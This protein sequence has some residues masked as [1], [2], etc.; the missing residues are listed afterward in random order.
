MKGLVFLSL[1]CFALTAKGQYYFNDII[2]IK[3]GNDQYKTLRTQKISMIK[4]LSFEP[5]NTPTE[6]FSVTQ[7]ISRDGKK[8]VITTTSNNQVS[9]TTNTY[10]LGVLKRTQTNNK[11][12]SNKTDYSYDAQGRISKVSLSTIDTFM[13]SIIA[14]SH[15]WTYDEYG[16]P[17][18]MLKIKNQSDTVS[19]FFKKDEQENI[20]EEIWKKNGRILESYYYYYN[21]NRQLTDIVRYNNRLKKLLPDYIYEYNEVNQLAQMTQF[22]LGSSNYFIWKYSYNDKG[23]KIQETCSD[24]SKRV[25]GRIEY[26]YTGL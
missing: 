8:M 19:I 9:I 1:S 23:L 12:I 11:N 14:E 4:A 17:A 15:E 24:K 5:D 16:A 7:E 20:T 21:N 22:S 2:S 26:Q 6:G 10:E 13:N 25:V 3:Q 18:S